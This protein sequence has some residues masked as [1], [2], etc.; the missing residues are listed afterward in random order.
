[1]LLSSPAAKVVQ[2]KQKLTFPD[3]TEATWEKML[4]ILSPGGTF[5]IANNFSF[6]DALEVLPFYDKYEF[7][8][9]V[10]I[11]DKLFSRYLDMI[12]KGESSWTYGIEDTERDTAIIVMSVELNLPLSK[13]K[14]LEVAK[15]RVQTLKRSETNLRRLLPLV[16]NDER[17]LRILATLL[18]GRIA[19]TMTIEE[20]RQEAQGEDYASKVVQRRTTV[21]QLERKILD[22]LNN[23]SG[24]SGIDKDVHLTADSIQDR[25]HGQYHSPMNKLWV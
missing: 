9:G 25:L 7:V 12:L 11:C 4:K 1:M 24:Y 6:S 17:T 22:P 5:L 14:A 20:I 13:T 8:D 21:E 18:H 19:K 10:R 15:H 2:E 3:I 23:S 16:E